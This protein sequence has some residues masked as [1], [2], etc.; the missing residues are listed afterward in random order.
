MQPKEKGRHRHRNMMIQSPILRTHTTKHQSVPQSEVNATLK[1]MSTSL[2]SIK[3]KAIVWGWE[4]WDTQ[5][6]SAK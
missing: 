5:S 1:Q 2:S 6:G 3:I 4:N